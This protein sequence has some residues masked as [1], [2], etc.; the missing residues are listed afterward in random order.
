M[1]LDVLSQYHSGFIASLVPIEQQLALRLCCLR[2]RYLP[3]RGERFLDR[4][5]IATDFNL[6]W[7]GCCRDT[8]SRFAEIVL[9]VSIKL[10]RE[11]QLRSAFESNIVGQFEDCGVV[12]SEL[13]VDRPS[14]LGISID[15]QCDA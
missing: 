13:R 9:I 5:Q 2:N 7:S 3:N 15:R 14:T 8:E 12:F 11:L 4:D 10:Q 6:S 1:H